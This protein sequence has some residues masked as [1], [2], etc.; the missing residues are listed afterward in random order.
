[1]HVSEGNPKPE[2]AAA[3]RAQFIRLALILVPI[4]LAS[5]AW[6]AAE[7]TRGRGYSLRALV[8]AGFLSAFALAY[9]L[10]VLA[11]WLMFKLEDRIRR[12]RSGRP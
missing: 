11:L 4:G 8:D 7:H 1:M 2:L 3:R 6:H 5:A 9:P 12:R 10:G